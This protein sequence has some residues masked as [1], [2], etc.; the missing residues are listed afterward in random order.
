MKKIIYIFIIFITM[1][2]AVTAQV[3]INKDGSAPS[4]GAI[5]DVKDATGH[6]FFVDDAT[7][8]VGIGTVSPSEKLEVQGSIRVI[9]DVKGTYNTAY[10]L[11]GYK[12]LSWDTGDG[13]IMLGSALSADIKFLSGSS[14]PLIYLD[15]SNGNVGIN[16]NTPDAGSILDVQAGA[17]IIKFRTD[18]G[19][20]V[21]IR[22]ADDDNDAIILNGYN[23]RGRILMYYDG[24]PAINFDAHPTVASYINAGNFG[25]G[26]D[27]PSEKLEVSG[28]TKVSGNIEAG[29]D[30]TATGDV[31]ANGDLWGTNGNLTGNL[32]VAGT[33]SFSD[34]V[35]ISSASTEQLTLT[36][37]NYHAGIKLVNNNSGNTYELINAQNGNFYVHGPT[38][39][40][41]KIDPSGNLSIANDIDAGGDI[42]ATGDVTANGDLW[43]D[44]AYITTDAEV[45]GDL[46][47]A[48]QIIVNSTAATSRQVSVT[49]NANIGVGIDNNAS[50]YPALY[51]SNAGGGPAIRTTQGDVKI[52]GTGSNLEVNNDITAGGDINVGTEVNRSAQGTA[53]LIPIAY[54]TVK[55]DGTIYDAGTGNW[56]A[57]WNGT[58]DRMEI[59][60]TGENYYYEDYTTLVT[61]L[62]SSVARM[63][64]TSSVNNKLVVYM[65]DAAGNKDSN[66]N[67][68][69]F[70]VYKH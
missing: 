51:V 42:S 11:G 70:V 47:V 54:G 31:T 50:S 29:G 26:T 46:K 38:T 37:T 61:P 68:F 67:S 58:Y 8:N 27:T 19:F 53:D 21:R 5:L 59:T 6:H 64:T 15:A 28:N 18:N 30:I 45:G 2:F 40:S 13:T 55:Y 57:S 36:G 69:S 52:E 66:G 1:N 24:N 43:G 14:D 56:S 25:I 33:G 10:W 41:L 34:D 60:I 16:T 32:D 22:E 23:T 35:S 12:G 39:S 63:A 4:T 65:W 9:G 17:K 7:G 44:N 49:A 48:D 62:N 3:A 20:G